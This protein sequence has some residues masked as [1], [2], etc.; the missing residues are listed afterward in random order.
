MAD[1]FRPGDKVCLLTNGEL[2][3]VVMHKVA[4]SYSPWGDVYYWARNEHVANAAPQVYKESEL[5]RQESC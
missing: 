3:L 4:M 5:V 2:K 1:K